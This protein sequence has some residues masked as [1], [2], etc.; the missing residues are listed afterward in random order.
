MKHI[1]Q[2]QHALPLILILLGLGACNTKPTSKYEIASNYPP[3]N[4][5]PSPSQQPKVSNQSKDS[6]LET[7]IITISPT[8]DPIVVDNSSDEDWTAL[9]DTLN[10]LITALQ[11]ST[12]TATS[13]TTTTT[14][15]PTTTTTTAAY[16]VKNEELVQIYKY[17][18]SSGYHEGYTTDSSI[19]SGWN[20]P[21]QSFKLFKNTSSDLEA[22]G[23]NPTLVYQYGHNPLYIRYYAQNTGYSAWQLHNDSRYGPTGFY[24]TTAAV[25]V[26]QTYDT[27][28]RTLGYACAS[29]IDDTILKKSCYYSSPYIASNW[30][31]DF[32]DPDGP[33][34]H[35]PATFYDWINYGYII[36]LVNGTDGCASGYNDTSA[37][38]FY[39][40]NW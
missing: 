22:T 15:T 28:Y 23:C 7:E 13:T 21:N 14:T 6:S 9:Y 24:L 37:G 36:K 19:I 20:G 12:T 26:A 5:S 16:S 31:T 32:K 38:Q 25:G 18:H 11:S 30:Q 4:Y 33:L 17:T 3:G 34:G 8:A 35:A 29:Q 10:T 39:V 2:K 40:P 27:Y 1:M